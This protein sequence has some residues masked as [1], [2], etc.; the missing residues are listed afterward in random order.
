MAEDFPLLP[1][2]LRDKVTE[3][4]AWL[5]SKGW[6]APFVTCIRR[7]EDDQER[8]YLPYA[9]QVVR[10]FQAGLSLEEKERALAAD[11]AKK[12]PE[13]L[14]AWARAKRSWHVDLCAL[15]L[16]NRDY[17]RLQRKEIMDHL[18]HGTTSTEWEVLEHDVGRG[19]HI[20]LAYKAFDR[21]GKGGRP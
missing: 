13:E 20:H 17:S 21:R 12:T 8:I 19:N 1:K 10:L 11:L 5:H 18:R 6:E 3:L 14:K 15:D 7:T 2:P 9:Q 16:R 4:A